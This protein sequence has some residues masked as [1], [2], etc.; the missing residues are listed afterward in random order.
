[1]IVYKIPT[2]LLSENVYFVVK[3]NKDTLI[4]DPGA[5]PEDL[6]AFIQEHDLNPVAIALTHAHYD[7]IGALDEVRNVY[8]VPVYMH[9]I[10][11]DFLSN[12]VLNLSSRHEPL[13]VREADVLFKE[14]GE[15]SIEGFDCRIEHV[16]GHSPGSTV[17]LFEKDGFAIV[18]DTLFKGGC[19]RTDLPS[20]SSHA[21]LMEGIN[22]HLMTLPDN[23]VILS[24][25]G[26]QTTIQQE[27]A[28][29][30]YLNGVTR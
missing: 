2:G 13:S 16:P 19:G 6:L 18:G 22:K 5:Q 20:S 21:E 12:P 26:D 4:F 8:P 25:H 9:H 1:M 30:P 28:T 14:M 29:N 15:V 10:E 7:H 3:D 23:T 17:Y 27:R 24:G 11:K